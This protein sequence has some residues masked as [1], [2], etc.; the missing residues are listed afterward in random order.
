MEIIVTGASGFLGTAI[1]GYARNHI[2]DALV[3]PMKSPRYGGLDL[4]DSQAP[5]LLKEF[6][7][8][9]P[10]NT[11]LIHVA[12]T[13]DWNTPSGLL[14]NILMSTHLSTWSREIGIGFNVFCSSVNVYGANISATVNTPPCPETFYGLGKLTEE[15]LWQIS[16]DESKLA[17]VRLAG[18]WGWQQRPTLFWNTLLLNAFKKSKEHPKI[19]MNRKLSFRNYISVSD[20]AK[21]CLEVATHKM[22]GIFLAAGKDIMSTGDYLDALREYS[23]NLELLDED[24]G[25]TDRLIYTPSVELLPWIKSFSENLEELWIIRSNFN[26]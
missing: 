26:M 23:P 4:T 15:R 6:Q 12:A 1:L 24:D 19:V 10:K 17:I 13:I 7:I 20:A 21:C 5:S 2:P 9:N 22:S 8:S 11:V 25:S 3:L 18:L 16:V 14:K